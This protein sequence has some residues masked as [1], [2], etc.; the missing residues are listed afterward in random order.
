MLL[1]ACIAVAALDVPLEIYLIAAFDPSGSLA[2]I[3]DTTDN[4]Y[5]ASGLLALL[6]FLLLVATG[7]TSI[8]LIRRMTK[9]GAK[10][11]P[12]RAKHKTHWAITGWFVPFLNLV[13]PYDMVKQIW[14]TSPPP[15]PGPINATPP[16]YFK[17]WWGLFIASSAADRIVG[18]LTRNGVFTM[19]QL[20]TEAIWTLVAQVLTVAAG[21]AFLYVLR[22]VVKRQDIAIQ[23]S[24]AA[25]PPPV[26]TALQSNPEARNPYLPPLPPTH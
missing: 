4:I 18:R 14:V 17:L 25:T 8:A 6:Q 15:P 20:S 19:R 5:L 23:A 22:A 12:G 7:I 3:T 16:S 13:R 26:P 10:L 21:L 1:S 9:N 2:D 24:W 11:Q